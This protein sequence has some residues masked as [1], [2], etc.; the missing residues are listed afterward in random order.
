[1]LKRLSYIALLVSLGSGCTARSLLR[2]EGPL[3]SDAVAEGIPYY[4]AKDI[5]VVDATVFKRESVK[6]DPAFPPSLGDC[7]VLKP[8]E[9]DSV[10]HQVAVTTVADRSRE[11]RLQTRSLRAT[12]GTANLTV[13][14]SGLLV[15]INTTSENVGGE[16]ATNVVKGLASLAG[17]A[18]GVA[19]RAEVLEGDPTAAPSNEGCFRA[20]L[21]GRELA[22]RVE[23]ARSAHAE[24]LRARHVAALRAQNANDLSSAA[25]ANQRDSVLAR[26]AEAAR[27]Q[28]E[29]EQNAEASAL[30]TFIASRRLGT[31]VVSTK[32][33]RF[34]INPAN[35]IGNPSKVAPGSEE[36]RMLRDAR[37]A[38]QL[39]SLPTLGDAVIASARPRKQDDCEKARGSDCAKVWFRVP[40]TMVLS[41][42]HQ[43]GGEFVP[44]ERGA[45]QL[46]VAID[47]PHFVALEA[48][49]VGAGSVKV[50]FGRH[51]N[52]TSIEQ[53][54]VPAAA[55]ASAGFASSVAGA[56][57]EL[58][59]GAQ[60]VA[61][62]QS[63]LI[64]IEQAQRAARL[65]S[66]QDQKAL[67]D[68]MVAL[69]GA[70]ATRE[71][72]VQRA[73]IETEIAVLTAQQ[74]LA[75]RQATNDDSAATRAEIE[76][77]R[78][79]IELLKARLELEALR[80]SAAPP[81]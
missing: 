18:L 78:L 43:R 42:F 5:L 13:N 39:D 26:A 23:A 51:G 79:D 17:I 22:A 54:S 2:T 73:Q 48:G 67:L 58:L 71:L 35:V 46:V 40:R 53:S 50:A 33:M 16:I 6:W 64:G 60:S 77:L 4:L 49:R 20:T 7:K 19:A 76:Q 75:A 61:E 69:D 63:T 8:V 81:E 41:V 31:R 1:M 68:A 37:V 25:A 3:S 52:P 10:V 24:L 66:L 15:G 32:Q 38:I 47:R 29:R 27:L 72:A 28:L 62:V 74:A 44:V 12:K 36:E 9:S 57:T 11:F 45:V 21:Q 34:I 59:A 14:E 30:T 56:R 80:K 55:V 70:S 65:K